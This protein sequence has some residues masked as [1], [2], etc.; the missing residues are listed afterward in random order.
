[1]PTFKREKSTGETSTALVL[2]LDSVVLATYSYDSVTGDFTVAARAAPA[3]FSLGLYR[4]SVKE[5]MDWVS[6]DV[7]SLSP[8]RGAVQR[9]STAT[10]IPDIDNVLFSFT[11]DAASIAAVYNVS[12]S[13]VTFQAHSGLVVN[14]DTFGH[15]LRFCNRISS[16]ASHFSNII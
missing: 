9:Y 7:N 14:Y 5:C 4:Q 2:S 12:T 16:S 10:S 6:I 13:T 1:M 11:K 15:L 3:I 8:A